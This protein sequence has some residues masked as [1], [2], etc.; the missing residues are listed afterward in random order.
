MRFAITLLLAAF[1]SVSVASAA[2]SKVVKVLPQYIDQKGR[3]ALSP[4]LYDRDAYQA[5]LVAHPDKCS[6]L[7][8][9]VQWRAAKGPY[10]LR[11]EARGSSVAKTEQKFSWELPVTRRGWFTQWDKVTVTGDEYKKLNSL[12]AWRVTL[13]NGTQQVG[14]QKSF[15]W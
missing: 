10:T 15:L 3:T 7:V 8:F 12:S 14:E 6:G 5:E 13:W 11:V 2:E 4:S 1:V 9:N